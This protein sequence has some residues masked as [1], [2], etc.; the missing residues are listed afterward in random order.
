MA[1]TIDTP[2]TDYGDT[3]I[4]EGMSFQ[5]PDFSVNSFMS[6]SKGGS[7]NDLVNQMRNR[8]NVPSTP[9]HRN[10]LATLRQPAA[11]NE[12]TPLLKSA[13]KRAA[14]SQYNDDG[15]RQHRMLGGPETPAA[16]KPGFKLGDT[17]LPQGS[18]I[19]QP[20]SSEMANDSGTPVP[21]A[22]SSSMMSTPLALP[23][24]GQEGML[25]GGNVLTLREQEAVS[26][27]T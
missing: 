4:A 22:A 21:P 25:D 15:S 20:S 1:H 27:D 8:H 7:R 23:R 9:Q 12:F 11:S 16:M 14:L 5:A 2:R 10:P 3:R 19:E 17:P 6:P 13:T 26:P 24:R 18:F